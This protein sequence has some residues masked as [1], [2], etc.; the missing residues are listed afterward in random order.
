MEAN[1]PLTSVPYERSRLASEGNEESIPTN[2]V[3]LQGESKL[4]A[5]EEQGV[6]GMALLHLFVCETHREAIAL[7]SDGL[8]EGH[9]P[10][11]AEQ[12]EAAFR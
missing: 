6:H 1:A 3:D 4:V 9:K 8:Q 5:R 2:G 12:F 11:G 7:F 10:L